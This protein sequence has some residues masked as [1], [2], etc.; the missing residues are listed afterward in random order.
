MKNIKFVF[1]CDFIPFFIFI[2]KKYTT[3][4]ALFKM[5]CKMKKR[6]NRFQ[7][8]TEIIQSKAVGNQ[9]ELSDILREKG[10]NVTQATLSRDLKQM[11]IYKKPVSNGL[12]KY[13]LPTENKVTVKTSSPISANET[14]LSLE[15]SGQLAVIKTKP[16][17]AAAIAYSIDNIANDGILGTI[18]GEDTI[19]VI[20]REGVNRDIVQHIVYQTF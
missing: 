16:G 14:V 1:F 5:S 20:L 8:I 18:A 13:A 11:K 19:L 15:F 6:I 3:F 17:Y 9:E 4:A 2:Y 7:A 12:Y 10:H